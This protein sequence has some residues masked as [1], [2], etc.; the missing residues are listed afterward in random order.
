MKTCVI[1]RLL[2]NFQFISSHSRWCHIVLQ[3]IRRCITWRSLVLHFKLYWKK[4][5]K[6]GLTDKNYLVGSLYI[7][8]S[9][10]A[11]FFAE[12]L[13]NLLHKLTSN[14][15]H[16]H[17]VICC[18]TNLNLL[19]ENWSFKEYYMNIIYWNGFISQIRLPN[20]VAIKSATLIDH[21]LANESHSVNKAKL[22]WTDIN[23]LF[24]IFACLECS[25]LNKTANFKARY[26]ERN[27]TIK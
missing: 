24:V 5:V 22:R 20:C 10:S 18:V 23:D 12:E 6:F 13:E 27:K 11:E 2:T 19:K 4:I 1:H 15:R 3:S 14:F 9:C 7:P 25:Y 21:I 17:V 16:F 8:L 26:R